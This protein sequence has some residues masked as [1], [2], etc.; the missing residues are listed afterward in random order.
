MYQFKIVCH[1]KNIERH[2]KCLNLQEQSPLIH[3]M[4]HGIGDTFHLVHQKL[5]ATYQSKSISF[6]SHLS[7]AV[8]YQKN[9]TLE[10][11]IFPF[12][13]TVPEIIVTYKRNM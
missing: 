5:L 6:P 11:K 2:K 7:Q 9:A 3:Y 12:K 13:H 8:Q 1:L 10:E 4:L